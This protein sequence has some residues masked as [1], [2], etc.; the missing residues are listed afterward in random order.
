M[1]ARIPHIKPSP[2]ERAAMEGMVVKFSDVFSGDIPQQII[3]CL[4]LASMAQK[5]A[6]PPPKAAEM[7]PMDPKAYA[8]MGRERRKRRKREERE[9]IAE[10]DFG[11]VWGWNM[12]V[13]RESE[14][15]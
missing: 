8:E 11:C 13:R 6:S 14:T 1:F 7:G 10:W 5:K 9:S 12:G 3:P 15:E 4:P 2:P